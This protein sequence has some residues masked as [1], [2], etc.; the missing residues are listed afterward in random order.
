M[1]K[2][3]K[4]KSKRKIKYPKYFVASIIL[5]IIS[6][7][8]LLFS[9]ITYNPSI[10][11]NTS[12]KKIAFPELSTSGYTKVNVDAEVIGNAGIV[13]LRSKCYR[14]VAYTQAMQAESIKKGLEGKI[15]FRPTVH[16]IIVS[17]FKDLGIKVL[18]LKVNDVVN[19]TYVG[20]LIIQQGNKI[21]SLDIRPS[22]GTAIAVRVNAPIYIKNEVLEKYG[23]RIC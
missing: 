21:L 12:L 18:M 11:Q 1:V 5:F 14:I 20:N 6:I 10:I 3:K 19:H 17:I 16:D 13:I 2:R 4:V 9:V 23:E 22:D 7:G 8:I 15:D